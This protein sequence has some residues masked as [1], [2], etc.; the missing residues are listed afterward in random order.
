MKK[1]IDI[2]PNIETLF[3]TRDE[4]LRLLENGLNVTIN[5][6]ADSIEIAGAATDV[7]RAEQ[8]FVD[9]EHLLRS[10]HSFVNGD[11]GALIRV[12]TSDRTATLRSL[13]EAGKQRSFGKRTVQPKSINQRRYLEA[14]EKHDMVFGV[15]PAGTGKTYLAV[16]MAISALLSKRVNRIVL[17][18]PAVEAGERLGFLPGTLQEKV[19]PYL[20]PLY[21]ALYDMLEPDKV[22]RYLEKSVIEIA[23][24][25][26]MRGRTL[27]D[28]F[29][30]LDEAQ[31]TTS[32][33]MKMFVTRLGFNSRAV[34][35]GDVTQIDLPNA[36]RSGLV[37]AIDIL[38]KVEGIHFCYFDEGDVVRHHLV[39][40]IIRAYEDYK[41]RN[42]QLSL[43]LELKNGNGY[44]SP[45]ASEGRVYTTSIAREA[46]LAEVPPAE[47]S[48]PSPD[49]IS[50]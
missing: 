19:D 25:A 33:Q 23:P 27:N 46:T 10:G 30:I 31:N 2:S 34:I 3:G 17:A 8:V 45:R 16:A 47:A 14:I 20:R 1:N 36:N 18:R 12:L 40:R 42:E 29:V 15:G 39:Q 44:A 9:Y 49:R 37:E 7:G 5:L 32:E 22:D 26:F 43:S 35:T 50:E 6:R 4:N 28:A 38:G 21:D 48:P 41:G 11:L 24:I 13:A